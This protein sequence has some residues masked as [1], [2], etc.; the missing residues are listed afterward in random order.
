MTTGEPS[1][2]EYVVV[3]VIAT[4]I[5]IGLESILAALFTLAIALLIKEM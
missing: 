2:E 1:Y 5:G 4:L 3:A